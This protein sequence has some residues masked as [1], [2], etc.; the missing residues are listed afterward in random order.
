M[1]GGEVAV[2][3]GVD[4]GTRGPRTVVQERLVPAGGG[5]VDVDGGGC[6]FDGGEAVVVV[7]GV[8]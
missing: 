1:L 4:E 2:A 5:V 7:E 3:G 6:G 8:E